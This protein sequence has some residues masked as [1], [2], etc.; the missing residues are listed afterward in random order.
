MVNNLKDVS[1]ISISLN[2]DLTKELDRLQKTL[3]FTGRSE[4]VRAGIRTFVQEEKQKQDMKGIKNAILMVVHADEF[5]DQV[6]GIKHDYENLI[7][8]HLHNKID[9]NRCVELFLL[10]GDAKKIEA[11]TKGF[12][13]NKKMDNV[14][15]LVL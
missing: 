1:I 13:T 15:L 14:K 9:N 12:L 11:V 2:N 4:I 3:G 6:A 5:D 10:D 8:T 7:K